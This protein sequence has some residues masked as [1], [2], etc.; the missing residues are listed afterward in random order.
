MPLN[1]AIHRQSKTQLHAGA[2]DLLNRLGGSAFNQAPHARGILEASDKQMSP[3]APQFTKGACTACAG[4][5]EFPADALGQV[6]A[7][8]HC[9]VE[10]KLLDN[11]RTAKPAPAA[12]VPPLLKPSGGTAPQKSQ[13]P[14]PAAPAEVAGKKF[15]IECPGCGL[16]VS[17]KADTCPS[18]GAEIQERSQFPW[19]FVVA[20]VVVVALAG[21]A[22]FL[23]RAGKLKLP[24]SDRPKV[25]KK[26]EK[27]AIAAAP[28]A[29]KAPSPAPPVAAT[30]AVKRSGEFKVVSHEIERVPGRSLAYVVG[31]VTND[32]DKQQFSVR[33]KFD[34]FDRNGGSVGEATDYITVIEPGAGWAFRALILDTNAASA[35]LTAL[36]TEKQ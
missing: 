14:A 17:V 19:K 30:K 2:K 35:K 29:A 34:L 36:E 33:V 25:A 1:V 6:I 15:F 9:G 4:H 28:P 20:A 16:E 11:L 23:H 5:I 18:C 26:I 24:G 27:P 22:F 13:A 31:T 12:A 3:E 10:T 21:G 8:P 7:C 32:A